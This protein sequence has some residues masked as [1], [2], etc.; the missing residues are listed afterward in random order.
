MWL[1]KACLL[2][3]QVAQ[4]PGEA[5]GIAEVPVQPGRLLEVRDGGIVVA[6]LAREVRTEVQRLARRMADARGF[7][8][9]DDLHGHP[10]DGCE[11]VSGHRLEGKRD[12]TPRRSWH[13]AD[14]RIESGALGEALGGLGPSARPVWDAAEQP[15]EPEQAG[16]LAPDAATSA[17]D[18]KGLLEPVEGLIPLLVAGGDLG[19][20]EQSPGPRAGR[21]GAT[22]KDQAEPAAAAGLVEDRPIHAQGGDDPQREVLVVVECPLQ[23][24]IYVAGLLAQAAA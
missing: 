6:A 11:I 8:V 15:P 9:L 19:G 10:L 2:G 22:R 20:A 1:P 16:C 3:C 24:K 12:A 21:D 7:A 13:V 5:G 17:I 14:L 18:G 4:H 23:G